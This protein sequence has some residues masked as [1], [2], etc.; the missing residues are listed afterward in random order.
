MS[1][2]DV[3]L[4]SEIC[5]RTTRFTL[6]KD[7]SP[8]LQEFTVLCAAAGDLRLEQLWLAVAKSGSVGVAKGGGRYAMLNVDAF[9]YA[10]TWS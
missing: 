9:R 10:A 8:T 5:S 1:N 3:I 4:A 6:D 7:S 2:K